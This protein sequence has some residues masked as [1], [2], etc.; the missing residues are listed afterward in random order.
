MPRSKTLRLLVACVISLT[1]FVALTTLTASGQQQVT[2]KRVSI[3]ALLKKDLVVHYAGSVRTNV[4]LPSLSPVV[5][6]VV[7]G[8]DPAVL[9]KVTVGSPPDTA[10]ESD[11]PGVRN[12]LPENALWL[13]VDVVEPDQGPGMVD[14]YWQAEMLAGAIRDAAAAEGLPPVIGMTIRAVL[15]NGSEAPTGSGGE[16]IDHARTPTSILGW[17]PQTLKT[18]IQARSRLPG[19]TLGNISLVQPLGLGA[20]IDVTV[21]ERS[22]KAVGQAIRSLI[23]D[24]RGQLEGILFRI[25]DRS[26]RLISASASATRTS[27]GVSWL[28][29]SVHAPCTG[30]VMCEKDLTPTHS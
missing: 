17:T 25:Y 4:P 30:G 28:D 8:L 13:Y 27:S 26:G 11:L 20:K 19:V 3:S 29:P 21:N 14:G 5:E 23:G 16:R 15:R 9:R 2:P 18:E 1:A 6:R 12:V 24:S 22:G 10:S 7:A